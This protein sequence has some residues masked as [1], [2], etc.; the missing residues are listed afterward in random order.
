VRSGGLETGIQ[1]SPG[2]L[3]LAPLPLLGSSV[4]RLLS[5][6]VLRR[7]WSGSTWV[8]GASLSPSQ[9][10]LARGLAAGSDGEETG[11]LGFHRDLNEAWTITARDGAT[12]GG[13]LSPETQGSAFA[14]RPGTHLRSRRRSAACAAS[15]PSCRTTRTGPPDV[16]AYGE[17]PHPS[18]GWARFC[19]DLHALK[20]DSTSTQG[21]IEVSSQQDDR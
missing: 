21:P 9:P 17:L 11:D 15:M 6:D 7:R 12:D 1:R 19:S 5:R 4:A 10:R 3:S 13:A 14:G 18:S 8:C 2:R 16:I 20:K